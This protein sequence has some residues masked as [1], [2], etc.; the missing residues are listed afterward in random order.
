M[1]FQCTLKFPLS[2]WERGKNEDFILLLL[3]REFVFDAYGFCSSSFI[4]TRTEVHICFKSSITAARVSSYICALFDLQ[5]V[6]E[7][8]I[9]AITK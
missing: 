7:R 8:T 4:Y 6:S 5:S 9:H 1:Q 2:L 3:L